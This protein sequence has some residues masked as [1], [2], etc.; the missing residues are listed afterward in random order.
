MTVKNRNGGWHFRNS[1]WVLLGLIPLIY[2]IPFLYIGKR[3]GNKRY[4]T[5]GFVVLALAICFTASFFTVLGETCFLLS[6]LVV[7]AQFALAL[8]VRKKYL[9]QL[10]QKE[11]RD[12][13]QEQMEQRNAVNPTQNVQEV[14]QNVI[15]PAVQQVAPEEKLNVNSCTEEELCAL[16]GISIVEAKKMTALRESRGDF[17]TVEAFIVAVG[18]KP[19]VAARIV[20]RLCAEPTVSRTVSKKTINRVLDF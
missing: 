11:D 12:A 16:P 17:D 4:T 18:I 7:I 5:I 15:Q 2:W 3:V 8:C 13:L 10:A 19:H 9:I 14:F 20:H 1:L 6:I